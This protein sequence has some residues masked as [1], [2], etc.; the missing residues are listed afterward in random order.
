M[1]S[2]TPSPAPARRNPSPS[3]TTPDASSAPP[4]RS[5]S[6]HRPPP[7]SRASRTSTGVSG[8][9]RSASRPETN[10]PGTVEETLSASAL[11]PRRTSRSLGSPSSEHD[12]PPF[13][14]S[15]LGLLGDASGDT[16]VRLS[17][18]PTPRRSGWNREA[19]RTMRQR[20][21]ARAPADQRR[22]LPRRSRPTPPMRNRFHKQSGAT[23]VEFALILPV[24]IALRVRHHRLRARVHADAD[25]P[26]CLA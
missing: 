12:F 26:W 4:T 3:S 19:R 5:T 22:P 17:T 7:R 13:P 18:S 9:S 10:V 6:S 14:Y 23:A 16:A 20:I 21:H 15:Q 8:E 11:E 24:L 25:H 2:A 1:A